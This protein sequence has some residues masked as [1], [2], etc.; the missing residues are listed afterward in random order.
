ML[1]AGISDIIIKDASTP[2]EQ[3]TIRTTKM[4]KYFAI[5]VLVKQKQKAVSLS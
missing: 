3:V 1:I 4:D 2:F 5:Q